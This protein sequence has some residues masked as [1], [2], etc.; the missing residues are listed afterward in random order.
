MTDKPGGQAKPATGTG[1]KKKRQPYWLI[2][3]ALIL[4]GVLFLGQALGLDALQ[5]T[6]FRIGIALL[7]SALSLIVGNGRMPGYLATAIIVLSTIA[8]Y[9]V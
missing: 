8:V 5:R 1:P 3:G 6:T 7:Y 4:G 2:Y 9:L